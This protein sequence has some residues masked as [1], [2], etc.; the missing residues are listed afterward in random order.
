M[1]MGGGHLAAEMRPR[2]D[3]YGR[4]KS[5]NQSLELTAT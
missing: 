4:A 1:T 2:E 3:Y 5:P